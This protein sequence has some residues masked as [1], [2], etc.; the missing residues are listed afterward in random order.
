[1]ALTRR[2]FGQALAAVLPAWAAGQ[3]TIRGRLTA[4]PTPAVTTADGVPVILSGD[5]LTMKVL[6][7]SR[8]NGSELEITG[9]STNGSQFR[10][11]PIHTNALRV[12]KD[13]KG[14]LITYWCE[15]CAIRTFAPGPCM[16]CQEES[17]LD[18]RES[19]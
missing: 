3:T 17:A 10:V 12:R 16:C 11:G 18:L 6:A 9:E 2:S 8:L 13:G 4:G 5:A 15:T 7:D 14:L 1:M 19:L